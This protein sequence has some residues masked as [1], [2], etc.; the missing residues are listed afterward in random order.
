[1]ARNRN[2]YR[3]MEHYMT[4]AL[5]LDL[6]LF[7]FFLISAGNGVIWLKVILAILCIAL[8]GACLAFL[9][10]SRELLRP[11]SMW[12]SAA[13][14]AILLCT[15]FALILNYPSPNPLNQLPT[16]F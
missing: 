14:A 15:I 16:T 8:S 10:I 9:Y 5:F 13:A 12:M 7:I 2:R 6:I 3:Q 4:C 11:R 1:M